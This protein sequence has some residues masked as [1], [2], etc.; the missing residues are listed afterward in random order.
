MLGNYP[1]RMSVATALK[2]A[3]QD[4]ARPR[5]LVVQNTVDRIFHERQYTPFCEAFG[6]PVR[7]GFDPSGTLKA[8]TYSHPSGHGREPDTV[9]RE[10]L[11]EGFPF[12]ID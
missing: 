1:L 3:H 9:L 4:G 5:L 12:T 2:K 6:L 7:G 11:D 10:I 8:K